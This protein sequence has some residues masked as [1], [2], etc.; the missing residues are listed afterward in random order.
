MN[1]EGD[2]NMGDGCSG[3]VHVGSSRESILIVGFLL[4]KY[5]VFAVEVLGL[6]GRCSVAIIMCL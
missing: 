6:S 2:T 4:C 5:P 1:A 3:N